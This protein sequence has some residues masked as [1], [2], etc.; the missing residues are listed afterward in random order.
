M[1]MRRTVTIGGIALGVLIAG[2]GSGQRHRVQQPAPPSPT[3]IANSSGPISSRPALR[4]AQALV[5]DERQNRVL[6]V[7]LP[8]GRVVRRVRVPNDPQDIA[9]TP[10]G[11]TVVVVSSAAGK[12]TLL[13]RS[14]LHRAWTFGGFVQPHIV[15]ISPDHS[16]AYVTDDSQGT[17]TAIR[18]SD[19]T[20]TSR[21]VVG[22]GAH[23]L[24]FSPS[25]PRVWVALGESARR[26]SILDGTRISHP[27]LIGGFDPGF[28]AH[29]LSF[30]PSGRQVWIS[31]AVGSEVTVFSAAS[32]RPLFRVPV[33]PPPQHIAFAGGSVYLTSG[34]GGRIEKVNA[35][36]GHILARARSPYGSFE[37]SAADGYVAASSLLRGT[38]AIYTPGLKLLRVVKLAPATREVAISR[39]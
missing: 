26:I 16:Y 25:E 11:G 33:G 12:V 4:P 39:P 35:V 20:V 30:S 9:A 15:A 24:A 3:A 36:N 6:V 8:S 5:T 32:R 10:N 34:Y 1:R 28:A 14:S 38:L 22:A 27:R 29:D 18:L 23:H 2:C 13:Q 31:S 37:L 21:T 7:A 19:M 17:V